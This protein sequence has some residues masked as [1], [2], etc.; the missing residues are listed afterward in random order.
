MTSA[1]LDLP[2]SCLQQARACLGVCRHCFD[3]TTPAQAC[4]TS[5]SD[6]IVSLEVTILLLGTKDELAHDHLGHCV[7]VCASCAAEWGKSGC[8]RCQQSAS[9]CQSFV[10]FWR[11]RP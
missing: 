11:G 2:Q 5:L 1:A 9:A 4:H 8:P 10:A 7:E 6:V 3:C